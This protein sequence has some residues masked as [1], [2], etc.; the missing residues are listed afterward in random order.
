MINY[1][2]WN[3]NPVLFAIG[4]FVLRWYVAL[5]IAGILISRLL[6][7]YIFRKE[8]K[9]A[10]DAEVLTRYILIAAIVGARFGYVLSYQPSLI[11]TKP[12]EI[13]LP[14]SFQPAFHFTGPDHLSGP[15]A[16]FGV[17]LALWIYSR[18]KKP[19][20][21]FF[22]LLDRTAIL[23]ALSSVFFGV[24]NLL[25]A[26]IIGKPTNSKMGFVF[27][28]STTDGLAKIPC[29]IMRNPGGKNPLN[30]VTVRKDTALTV[31]ETGHSP[32]I[33]YLFFK[34]GGTEQLVNEFLIGDVKTFLFDNSRLTY[35]S[36]AEPLHYTIFLEKK[37]SYTARIRTIGIARHPT[38]LYEALSFLSIFLILFWYW[39]RKKERSL[40]ARISAVYFIS[41]GVLYLG[42]GFLKERQ[43]TFEG[44][45]VFSMEQ[46]LS[47]LL[48]LMGIIALIVSSRSA[49]KTAVDGKANG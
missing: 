39:N 18:K 5:Y 24:G 49:L 6:L 17:M 15:G 2:I 37:D 8:A 20:Q 33:L 27:T 3:A 31:T 10:A 21:N 28:R 36:G 32:I 40:T 29:C 44:G 14:I 42:Y 4:P 22:Q 30:S 25:N 1:I 48:I 19:G 38:Q 47:I 23:I 16:I 34:P 46:I 26:E 12:L 41:A 7:L 35:E 45:M 43:A 9:P 13:F 11:W